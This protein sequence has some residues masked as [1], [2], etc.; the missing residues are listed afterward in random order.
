MG[1]ARPDQSRARLTLGVGRCF[2]LAEMARR[3]DGSESLNPLQC[4]FGP[5]LGR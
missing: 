2:F 1:G 3:F 5:V 4:G